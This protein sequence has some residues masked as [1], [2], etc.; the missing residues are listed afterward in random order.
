MSPHPREA[1]DGEGTQPAAH[2]I[3]P[4]ADFIKL[5]VYLGGRTVSLT[6]AQNSASGSLLN[7][8][9]QAKN[10]LNMPQNIYFL[11]YLI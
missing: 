2:G 10:S 3:A 4:D 7:S 6:R 8:S 9:S 5:R 11:A 1:V